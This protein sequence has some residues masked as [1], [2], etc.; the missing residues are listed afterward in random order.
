MLRRL[1]VTVIALIALILIWANVAEGGLPSGAKVD[2]VVV[3]KSK[4]MLFLYQGGQLLKSYSIS[5]GRN[6]VGH[7]SQEGDRRTPEGVY[8]IDRHKEGSA[9]HRALH[10]SYPSS[11][12]REVAVA[13]NVSP[14]GDIM[15]HGMHNGLGWIGKL[16]RVV[17]WTAG[18]IAVTNSEI[19]EIWSA[20]PDGTPIEIRA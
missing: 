15:I 5:L 16:H 3:E 4:R 18:C 2:R 19:E 17:N 13:R 7:K 9:F 12:D 6:P 20:V 8:L 11:H 10:V 14:G 1:T